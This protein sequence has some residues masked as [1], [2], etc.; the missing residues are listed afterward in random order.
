MAVRYNSGGVVVRLPSHE[1]EAGEGVWAKKPKPSGRGSISGMPL[2]MV[3]AGD[4]GDVVGWCV[5]G[6][7][8][9]GVVC[10]QSARQGKGFGPK[11][12]TEPSWLGFVRAV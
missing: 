11:P 2:G 12:E 3:A 8:D 5:S 1:R 10:L 9:G 7:G 4:G 6:G